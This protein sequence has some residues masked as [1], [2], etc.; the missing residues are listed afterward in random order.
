[1]ARINSRRF[2]G[3]GGRPRLT[4][5]LQRIR[6]PS[7]CQRISVAG[8]TTTRASFQSKKRDSNTKPSRVTP[9]ARW[10]LAL[11]ST[12]SASCFRRKRFSAA[13]EA[14]AWRSRRSR[15][16]KSRSSR[17]T[18]ER[19]RRKPAMADIPPWRSI[20]GS[21]T[22]SYQEGGSPGIPASTSSPALSPGATTTS[23]SPTCACG[24]RRSK[25]R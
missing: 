16:A 11:R 10:D 13:R 9:S 6:N 4:F 25:R 8:F 20:A 18:A 22:R 2:G 21:A 5:H 24:W 7:R 19:R 1:M 23:A 14:L 3:R 15:P 17:E 12:K